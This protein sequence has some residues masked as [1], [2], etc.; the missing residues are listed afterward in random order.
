MSLTMSCDALCHLAGCES[1]AELLQG[2]PTSQQEML[3]KVNPGS[4]NERAGGTRNM[5]LIRSLVS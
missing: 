5:R 4:L 1:D 3:P 2:Q